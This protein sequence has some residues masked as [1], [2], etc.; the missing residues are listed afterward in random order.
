M[1]YWSMSTNMFTMS[2]TSTRTM[3]YRLENN[4]IPT[5]IVTRRWFT[6]THTSPMRIIHTFISGRL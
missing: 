3:S 6:T 5:G 2:T 4:G 1:H